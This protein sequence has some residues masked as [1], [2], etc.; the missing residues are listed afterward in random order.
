MLAAALRYFRPGY[1]PHD[2]GSTEQALAYLAVSPA[3]T[4]CAIRPDGGVP[5][6]NG[7]CNAGRSLLLGWATL[8]RRRAPS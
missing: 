2:Q 6:Q 8:S 5:K 7:R 4:G 1:T 3:A